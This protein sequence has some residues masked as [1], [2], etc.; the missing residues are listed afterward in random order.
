MRQEPALSHFGTEEKRIPFFL[1]E[2]PTILFV[3]DRGRRLPWQLP[4]VGL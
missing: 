4:E 2:K 3:I 1:F